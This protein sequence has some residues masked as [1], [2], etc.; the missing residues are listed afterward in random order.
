M[1][2]SRDRYRLLLRPSSARTWPDTGHIAGVANARR[3]QDHDGAAQT[4]FFFH[5]HHAFVELVQRAPSQALRN[6]H[7]CNASRA[8]N[9]ACDFGARRVDTYQRNRRED[10]SASLV[11]QRKRSQLGFVLF[12]CDCLFSSDFYS[13]VRRLYRLAS[14]MTFVLNEFAR[15]SRPGRHAPEVHHRECGTA[16]VLGP[17]TS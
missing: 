7:R 9:S 5:R 6:D 15:C 12:C 11:V 4:C 3:G 10:E 1:Q 2:T 17:G 8:I 14:T 16:A 13:P